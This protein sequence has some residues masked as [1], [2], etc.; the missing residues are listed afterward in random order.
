MGHIHERVDFWVEHFRPDPYVRSIL[1]QGFQVPV[2]WDK[3]PESYEEADNKSDREYHDFVPE[4][5]VG[6]RAGP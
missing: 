1:Y 4:E 5:A 2:D 6:F 3:I